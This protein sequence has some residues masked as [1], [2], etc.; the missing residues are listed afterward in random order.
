MVERFIADF[1]RLIAAQPELIE[2][3]RH[4]VN[5]EF[6]EITVYAGAQDVGKIIGKDGNMINA[7][8][9]VVSGCKAKDHISYR[10]LVKPLH[11]RKG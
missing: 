9:T 8:K 4:D 11:E 3:D 7:I 5:K 2:V 10:I 1:A 6:S